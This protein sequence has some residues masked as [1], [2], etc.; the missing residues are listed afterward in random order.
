MK[1][2]ELL[3]LA[4]QRIYE[5]N[6]VDTEENNILYALNREFDETHT[7]SRI[8]FYLLDAPSKKDRSD[9][10][11]VA[12]L[13]QLK[14]PETLIVNKSWK[15]YREH[16]FDDGRIDI[17]MESS[18]FAVVIEMKIGA[19]DGPNQLER[20]DSFYKSR[21][22]EYRLYYLTLDGREPTSQSLGRMDISNLTCISFKKD[23]IEWLSVCLEYTEYGGYRYS[24][25]KQYIGAVRHITDKGVEYKMSVLI[26][27]SESAFAVISLHKELQTVI[28]DV[29]ARFLT[30]LMEYIESNS[31]Y[32]CSPYCEDIESE[33]KGFYFERRKAYPGFYTVLESLKSGNE[34]Y[35]YY[36]YVVVVYGSL[37]FGFE[38]DIVKD[39]EEWEWAD[40]DM[41]REKDS[42]FCNKCIR[43]TEALQLRDV[44]KENDLYWAFLENSKGEKLDFRHWSS[45]VIEL[46]DDMD[47]QIEYIG[48]Y[49]VNHILDRW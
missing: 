10:F 33:V 2:K 11:L 29:M 21:G 6:L 34:L 3:V 24:F 18:E 48:N 13:R 23:I 7:H 1:A 38:F 31:K 35:R 44:K 42:A 36:L 32:K 9:S 16:S 22:K 45:S 28:E 37:Y 19:E 4:K 49:I 46:I 15:V 40:I 27:D 25:I 5:K 39:N 20:Y 41:I 43:K 8:I 12:F 30:G 26:N 17:V 47:I 14:I